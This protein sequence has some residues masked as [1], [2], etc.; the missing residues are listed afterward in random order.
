M[1]IK[2]CWNFIGWEPFF[3]ITWEPGFSQACSFCRMLMN[4]KN[5]RFTQI[6]DKTND[7]I[8]LKSPKT[9]FW[10]A[11]KVFGPFLSF[12]LFLP[13]GDFAQNIRLSHTTI[14]GPLTLSYVLEKTNEP[15]LKNLTDR[16]KDGRKD[17]KTDPIL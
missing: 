16:L 4:N 14:Y 7:I 17:E 15:N 13:N 3:A 2:E 11:Q 1:T 12:L 8:F 10:M 9:F 6:P 5:V